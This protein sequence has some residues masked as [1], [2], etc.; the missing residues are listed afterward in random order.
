MCKDDTHLLRREC[1]KERNFVC[2]TCDKAFRRKYHL[3]RH[4]YLVHEFTVPKLIVKNIQKLKYAKKP[5]IYKCT[6]CTKSYQLETS[7]RR[8]QRLECGVHPKYKC[9]ICGKQFTHKFVLTHHLASC[10]KKTAWNRI[11]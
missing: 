3:K 5:V 9:I 2:S 11:W 1:K 10:K 7:L 4:M 6:R 8:H